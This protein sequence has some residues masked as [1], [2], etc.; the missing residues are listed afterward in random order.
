[1]V[2]TSP[3][4]RTG[5]STSFGRMPGVSDTEGEG[6]LVTGSAESRA[7][8]CAQVRGQDA[9]S[10]ESRRRAV[11]TI[12]GSLAAAVRQARPRAHGWRRS[13]PSGSGSRRCWTPPGAPG[14]TPG[15]IRWLSP[16]QMRCVGAS[17][18]PLT[19]RR[20]PAGQSGSAGRG[21]SGARRI[22][23]T[24]R[25]PG[26]WMLPCSW[27]RTIRTSGGCRAGAPRPRSAR[28]MPGWRGRWPLAPEP[29][30]T[31]VSGPRPG[32]YGPSHLTSPT[33]SE[34]LSPGRRP[35]RPSRHPRSGRRLY[36]LVKALNPAG[37]ERYTANDQKPDRRVESL[38]LHKSVKTSA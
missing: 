8:V 31:P 7:R 19:P 36:A 9:W 25:R 1:M 16:R 21:R 13:S 28:S 37:Q 35:Q 38:K 23:W 26:S 33:T 14:T 6:P 27:R 32:R 18:P 17:R 34:P 10:V 24:W 22:S 20:R 30:L 15:A 4:S 11:R 2:C 5:R 29:W 12:S 3:Q